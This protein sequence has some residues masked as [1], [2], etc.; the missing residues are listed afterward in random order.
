VAAQL[1]ELGA[2]VERIPHQ[3]AAGEAPLG[4]LVIGHLTGDGPHV[5]VIGHMD[6]VFDPG[7]AAARPF[8][9]VGERATGPG[10]SDMKGGLLAGLHVLAALHAVGA[11]PNVTF[12]ANPDEEIGSPF[13]TPHIR[14]L[15]ADHDAA[16][17]TECA[18]ANGDIVSARKG[19]ADYRIT[20]NGRAAHAGIEPE[21]GRSA[22][23]E[24]ARQVVALHDLNGRWPGVTL[25]A[26]VIR[27]GT[28]PNVVAE[29]CQVE[30]DLRATTAADFE[31]AAAEVAR[32]LSHATIDGVTTELTRVAHH[33]PMERSPAS[34]RLAALAAGIAAE[35]GF[36][37]NDTATGGASD[38]NT[39]SAAGLP[40]LDG[41]GPIGGDDH[42]VDEWLDLGSIVPRTTL[43]A[44]LLAR[45]GEAL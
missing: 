15:A 17:V 36:T 16:L 45:I 1:G 25:N 30:L 8:T 29:R 38:A 33:P 3:P 23:L 10:V 27:G 39:T 43:L 40:S 41:L 9:V 44:G 7:T 20:L 21:K 14:R 19:I 13:S 4:D 2:A 26:G 37:V 5:L 35:L 31:A 12:V 28:R 24:A 32:I 11:R 18:R 22:I 6:T 34:A 42:S